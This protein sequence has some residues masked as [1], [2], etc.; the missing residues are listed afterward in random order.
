VRTPTNGDLLD[1]L[2]TLALASAPFNGVRFLEATKELS[3]KRYL[4]LTLFFAIAM[5]VFAIEPQPIGSVHALSGSGDVTITLTVSPA[6]EIRIWLGEGK[7]YSFL[8][9]ERDILLGFV[10]NAARKIDIAA[11]NKTTISYRQALGRFATANA[12]LVSVF[13]E[14]QG[15]GLSYTVM[16]LTSK[17]SSDVLL[18]DLKETQKFMDLLGK[19]H[20]LVDEYNRQLILFK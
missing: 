3:V 7:S 12:A 16:Q 17:G 18:L 5:S 14:T 10:E 20:S 4:M 11:A 1:S 2:R 6:K 15:Y 19:A 9:S 8:F 13:F